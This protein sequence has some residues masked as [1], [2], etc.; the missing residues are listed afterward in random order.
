MNPSPDKAAVKSA[1][2]RDHAGAWFITSAMVGLLL[3]QA[4]ATRIGCCAV[5]AEQGSNLFLTALSTL[6][7][8]I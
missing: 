5:L 1:A 3:L 8:G 6:A 7:S 4:V 2:R